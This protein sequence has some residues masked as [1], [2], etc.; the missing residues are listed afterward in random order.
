MNFV[1]NENLVAGPGGKVADGFPQLANVVD[2]GI[3]GTVDLENIHAPAGGN[4]FAGRA[5]VTGLGGQALFA[6]KGFGQYARSGGFADA[7]G[8]G[9]QKR[10]MNPPGSDGVAQR[11][12]DMFLSDQV[13]ETLRAPLAGQYQVRHGAT[14]SP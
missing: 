2:P 12:A 13:L 8:T 9:E 7:A 3:G 5:A 1:D 4:L 6:V 11:L 14:G 10:V